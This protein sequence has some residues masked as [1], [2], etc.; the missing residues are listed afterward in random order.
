MVKIAV[1]IPDDVF[2][3]GEAEAR[4]RGVNRS[5]L[6]TEALRQLTTSRASIDA[7]IVAGYRQ[8]PQGHDLDVDALAS[9]SDDLGD[10][11]S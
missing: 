2:A 1:S 10:Y 11:P 9:M 8:Y 7:A 3:A 4:R 5:A 6:Y